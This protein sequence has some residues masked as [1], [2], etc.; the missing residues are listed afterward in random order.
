ML[1]ASRPDLRAVRL[2]GNHDDVVALA[3]GLLRIHILVE[4]VNQAEDVR[5]VLLQDS[6]EVVSRRG[7]RRVLAGDAAAGEGL[8]N[9]VVKV[10][11]IRHQKEGEIPRHLPAHLLGEER[12][13]IGLAAALRMPEHAEPAEVRVRPLDDVNWT[14]RN[15]GDCGASASPGCSDGS[16]QRFSSR[17]RAPLQRQ[18]DHP[19]REPPLRRELP[20]QLLLMLDRGHRAV[21]AEHLMVPRHHLPRGAGLALVE[22]DEVLDDDR[23]A[24]HAP[25]C[26]RAALRHRP[27]LVRLVAAASIRR[28][29]PIRW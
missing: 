19:M 4:F 29:A 22:Q 13:G 26:R 8:V 7:A 6:F 11:P 5:V 1:R 27:A 18:L 3:V 24:G 10:V 15:E 14:F 21:D 16:A 12:H 25:A 23:A 17:E 2:V 9:L 20:L 28:N